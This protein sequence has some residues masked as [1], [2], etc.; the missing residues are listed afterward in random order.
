[1]SAATE[2]TVDLD[3][4]TLAHDAYVA[5]SRLLDEAKTINERLRADLAK[6][7]EYHAE[8]TWRALE[9]MSALRFALAI[10]DTALQTGKVTFAPE[11]L[12]HINALRR[13]LEGK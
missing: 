4:S 13:V 9:L 3:Q 7:R 5:I 11:A 12:A 2:A 10:I 6:E 1:M 8:V